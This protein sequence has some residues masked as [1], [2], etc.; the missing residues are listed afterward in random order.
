MVIPRNPE[1]IAASCLAALLAMT[2]GGVAQEDLGHA[3]P[4]NPEGIATSCLAALLAMTTGANGQCGAILNIV[5]ATPCGCPVE[6][7]WHARAV[8][9]RKRLEP[10]LIFRPPGAG[11][12]RGLNHATAA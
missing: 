1:G 9:M 6:D 2:T 4:R 11:G 8:G 5:G 7:P 3:N 12:Y 10:V